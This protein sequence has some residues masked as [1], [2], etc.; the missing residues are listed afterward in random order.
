MQVNFERL[1][2]L[3]HAAPDH[4]GFLFFK[5]AHQF[6]EMLDA[7]RKGNSDRVRAL[8]LK[9]GTKWS[10]ELV[11]DNQSK[12]CEYTHVN[13]AGYTQPEPLK[14]EV[15]R[16]P[17]DGLMN[18]WQIVFPQPLF[19]DFGEHSKAFETQGQL[20]MLENHLVLYFGFGFLFP[21]D[22]VPDGVNCSSKSD[23]ASFVWLSQTI[24]AWILANK[25]RL[26][27]TTCS[28]RR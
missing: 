2:Q 17:N 12:T 13:I 5:E 23:T 19:P 3:L 28:F 9:G 20:L 4:S 14:R 27:Q 16:T 11:N 25:S 18:R 26:T 24:S 1:F 22:Q 15:E 6:F 7:Y 8:Q 10:R 21:H